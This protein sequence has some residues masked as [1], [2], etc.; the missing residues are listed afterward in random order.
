LQIFFPGIDFARE[1]SFALQTE[2]IVFIVDSS[3]QKFVNKIFIKMESLFLC[4]EVNIREF[5]NEK[6][7]NRLGIFTYIAESELS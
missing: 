6:L 7:M 4:K 5:R 3:E 1:K 2:K